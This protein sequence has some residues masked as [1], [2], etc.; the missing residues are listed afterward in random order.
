MDIL[1]A[2]IDR[3]GQKGKFKMGRKVDSGCAK[4]ENYP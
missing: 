1:E 4:A 2:K 3:K